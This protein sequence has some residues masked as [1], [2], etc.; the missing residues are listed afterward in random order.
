MPLGNKKRKTPREEFP[1]W[2]D[3]KGELPMDPPE[4]FAD[5]IQVVE[6]IEFEASVPTR[7]RGDGM[8]S[9]GFTKGKIV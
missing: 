8:A 2:K 7:R 9:R 6:E 4:V 1:W 3:Y 5:P